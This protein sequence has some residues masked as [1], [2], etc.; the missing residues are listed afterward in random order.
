[1]TKRH[2]DVAVIGSGPAGYPAAKRIAN[3]GLSCALIEEKE[4][5]GT[6]LNRGCIPTKN[7]IKGA[8][9]L[10]DLQKAARF[11]IEVQ[12]VLLDYKKMCSERDAVVANMRKNLESLL[13]LDGV[14]LIRGRA[15]FAGPNELKILGEESEW[16]TANAIIIATGSESRVIPN[17]PI[18][19]KRVHDSTSLL[20]LDTLPKSLVVIG[21]GVIGCEFASLYNLLGT[22]VEIIELLPRIV[23]TIP[24]DLG[25]ALHKALETAGITIKTSTLVEKIEVQPNE[26]QLLLKDKTT[27]QAE[28][29]L[30]SVGRVRNTDNLNLKNIGVYVEENGRIPVNKHMETN[31]SGIYAV[32]DINSNFWLAHVATHQGLIA[33]DHILKKPMKMNDL[34]VPSVIFTLP[35]VAFVGL[36]EKEALAKGYAAKAALFPFSALGKSLA[37]HGTEGFAKIIFDTKTEQILGAQVIGKDAGVLIAEMCV[38][39]THEFT[40]TSIQ[41]TIH[42]HPTLAEVWAELA[43][44]GSGIPLHLPKRKK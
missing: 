36:S 1:M 12:G 28:H 37:S 5:G 17:F 3:A 20:K 21:G 34:A 39:L 35:E 8:E 43:F 22:K 4:V 9:I 44:L 29:V 41:E 25:S 16:I 18:D 27:L 24:E 11:G 30:V 42:A 14:T 10:Q 31:V 13:K 32:G 26:V 15:K 7:M 6:C 19:G 33:A 23:T 2:F 40:L 38:A